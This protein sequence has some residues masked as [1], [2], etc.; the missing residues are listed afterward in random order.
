[1][2]LTKPAFCGN[3]TAVNPASA[4]G[5]VLIDLVDL[6]QLLIVIKAPPSP[7]PLCL[8]ILPLSTAMDRYGQNS[9][10]Y[11]HYA[12]CELSSFLS[13]HDDSARSDNVARDCSCKL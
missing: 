6:C 3:R 10:V 13:E 7:T 9:C 5:V 1:M 2:V 4:Q 12:P 11:E 8:C